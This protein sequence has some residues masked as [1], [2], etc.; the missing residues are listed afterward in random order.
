[1]AKSK[2]LETLFSEMMGL[3]ASAP[4]PPVRRH[5]ARAAS[6]ARVAKLARA[7]ARSNPLPA[8]RRLIPDEGNAAQNVV[9][10]A[11]ACL[12]EADSA[13][14]SILFDRFDA[15]ERKRLRASLEAIGAT[16]TAADLDRLAKADA[17]A[18]RTIDRHRVR[19]VKEIETKLIRYCRNNLAALAA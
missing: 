11:F 18:R 14:L 19:H 7:L 10:R 15:R 5:K 8:V 16:R 6:P 12:L 2:S 13:G 3:V 1:M 9:V 17:A 4:P